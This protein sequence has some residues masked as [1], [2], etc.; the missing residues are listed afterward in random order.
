M[1]PSVANDPAVQAAR[2]LN[3]ARE[4][5]IRFKDRVQLVVPFPVGCYLLVKSL[6]LAGA[7]IADP[8]DSMIA[9]TIRGLEAMGGFLCLFVS[10]R[11]Y[12]KIR[13]AQKAGC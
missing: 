12:F 7:S 6:L 2:L 10:L 5:R 3:D 4:P 9:G 13:R 1:I 8:I 11:A